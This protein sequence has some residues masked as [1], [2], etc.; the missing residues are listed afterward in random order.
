MGV[1]FAA[2]CRS[3]AIE[4]EAVPEKASFGILGDELFGHL[5]ARFSLSSWW[6]PYYRRET[7]W[8]QN[9]PSEEIDENAGNPA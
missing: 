6:S 3:H 9:S 5:A 1:G 7:R 8:V 2:E 4:R